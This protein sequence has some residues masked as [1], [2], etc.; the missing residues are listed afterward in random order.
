MKEETTRG[1]GGGWIEFNCTSNISTSFPPP[2]SRISNDDRRDNLMETPRKE[3]LGGSDVGERREELM[4]LSLPPTDLQS[5]NILQGLPM[6][7]L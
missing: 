6:R 7:P 1:G 5:R 2:Y 4:F 3:Y